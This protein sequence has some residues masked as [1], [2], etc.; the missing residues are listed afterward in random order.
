[1]EM[2]TAGWSGAAPLRAAE[3]MLLGTSRYRIE[4]KVAE[5]GGL[6]LW[7]G[8]DRVYSLPVVIQR[9]ARITTLAAST[10]LDG[11]LRLTRLEHSNLPRHLEAFTERTALYL[12]MHPG[13]GQLLRD[14]QRLT[15]HQ[16]IDIGI[17]IC[18]ALNYLDR[19]A[20]IPQHVVISPSA[21]WLTAGGRV[22]LVAP[23]A[24]ILPAGLITPHSYVRAIGRTLLT[25]LTGQAAPVDDALQVH[26]HPELRTI[27]RRATAERASRRFANP[28]DLRFALL[29]LA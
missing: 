18:N 28:A 3:G 2:R 13:R 29:Q 8:I 9:I 26:V 24:L 4:G 14:A 1:M 7:E 22:K 20:E 5:H 10:A 21:L 17:Q 11:W 27:L 15:G 6:S 19:Q 16:V 12:V 25:L 23:R